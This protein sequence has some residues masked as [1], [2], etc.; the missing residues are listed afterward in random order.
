MNFRFAGSR[1]VTR[2]DLRE[3]APFE[4]TDF[5]GGRTEFGNPDLERTQIQ[6]YDFRWEVFPELGGVIAISAF[7][8][9]FH[10]PIEQIVEPQ[11]EVRITY[12]NAL[13]ANNYELEMEFRQNLSVLYSGLRH[14]SINTNVAFISSRVELP[15]IGIQTSSERALQGQSPYIVNATLGY[16]NS[17]IGVSS[18]IAYHVFG[19]RITEVGN[20]GIP[21]MFEQPRSQLDA[22][23]SRVIADYYRLSFSAKN[24]LDPDVIFK[25]GDK[26]YIRYHTGRSFSFGVSYSLKITENKRSFNKMSRST[27]QQ[28]TLVFAIG[29]AITVV[30]CSD[31]GGDDEVF[32]ETFIS[33]SDGRKVTI[34]EGNITSDRALRANNDYLLRGAVFVQDGVTLTVEAGTTV[35]GEGASTGALVVAQGG[36][37]MAE[38]TADSPIVFTSDALPGRHQRGQCGGLIINGHAPTNQGITQGEGNTGAFG[39]NDPNDSSGVL[40]YVRVEWAGIEFSPDN[41]LNGIAFQGVGSGTVVDRVQVHFNQDDG[42]EMFGGTVNL[43]Y[44]LVTGARGDSFDW[45]DGW[46]GKGQ[47]WVAQQR[48]D[49][50]DNG[51]E[52]DNSSKNNEALPRS[53]ATIYNAT[54][55]GDPKGPESDIGMLIREGSAGTYRNFIV[56]GFN[57]TGLDINHDATYAQANSG[58]L[59]VQNSIFFGNKPSSFAGADGGFDDTAWASNSAF[60]NVEVDPML[61]NPFNLINPDFRPRSGSPAT[62]GSVRAARPP[63]DGFFSSV[64]FIGGVDPSDNWTTGWTT[65]AQN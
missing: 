23:V 8:K 29:I 34:L 64:G 55:V 60:N 22:T 50:A 18:S 39:G 62:N 38:G 16:N 46:T 21:D 6:N 43:K 15:D 63:S 33:T 42:I 44:A 7:Y 5:V 49:D 9:R 25:Q 14:F 20:H 3:L 48:G 52:N 59:S 17:D 61:T 28:L 36:K 41:E 57:K 54:L 37:L 53:S 45:T 35:F 12:D 4:F 51:F 10:K 58:K 30:G 27:L 1:T 47:F 24:L 40:R 65:T 19:R 32:S 13:G 31:D 56:T 2:P 11:A 26:T